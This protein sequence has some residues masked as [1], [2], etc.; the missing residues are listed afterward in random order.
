M[1]DIVLTPDAEFD[2]NEIWVYIANESMNAADRVLQ[3]IH[4]RF[5][6]LA[7]NEEMGE[8]IPKIS[9]YRYRRFC[10]ANY[11]IYYRSTEQKLI[12]LRVLHGARDQDATLSL[13]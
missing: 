11:A 6:A 13:D 5:V 9:R 10:Y 4:E 2:L 3:G 7:G 8:Q 1:L 12:V